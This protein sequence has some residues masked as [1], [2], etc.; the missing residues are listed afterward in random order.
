MEKVVIESI[1]DESV[2]VN[3][4][5]TMLIIDFAA[6]TILIKGYKEMTVLGDERFDKPVK[7]PVMIRA[8]NLDRIPIIDSDGNPIMRP[9]EDFDENLALRGLPQP[10]Q[11]QMTM[12][13]FDFFRLHNEQVMQSIF[14]AFKRRL[15]PNNDEALVH[16]QVD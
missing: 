3:G 14:A 6:K 7:E 9:Y 13:E 16:I 5:P 2:E 1:T 10:E 8:S 15:D 12:G 4:V 11:T